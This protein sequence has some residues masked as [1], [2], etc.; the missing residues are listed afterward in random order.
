MVNALYIYPVKSLGGSF[1]TTWKATPS[2]FEYDRKWML[3]DKTNRFIT[4]RE[5]PQLSTFLSD[6]HDGMVHVSQGTEHISWETDRVIKNHLETKVWDDPAYVQEVDKT[7]D[8]FFSDLLGTQVRLV[9]QSQNISRQHFATK[10]NEPI[11]VSLADGYPF[12]CIG[13][14]SIENLNAKLD[15]PIQTDRFRPNIVLETNTAHEEDDYDKIRIGDVPFLN[16]KPC[17]RCM[18]ININQ[19]TSKS[20]KEPLATLNTYRKTDNKIFFG[21]NLMCMEEG[22]ISVG[23]HCT[24]L[25]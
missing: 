14:K 3:I 6:V 4:Q 23:E 24:H 1:K 11:P 19:Q 2:G 17:A 22:Y 7:V 9:K 20:E 15:F 25:K 12:L 8:N 5:F 18:V 13:S 10:L 21:T 16:L